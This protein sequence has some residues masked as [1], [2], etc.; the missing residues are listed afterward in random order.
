MLH[1]NDH[2][3]NLII[4]IDLG[5]LLLAPRLLQLRLGRIT[6]GILLLKATDAFCR[7]D[8]EIWRCTLQHVR[9]QQ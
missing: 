9:R 4:H 2:E 8:C 1:S 6:C 7:V 3:D 5:I